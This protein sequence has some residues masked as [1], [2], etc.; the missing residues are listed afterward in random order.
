MLSAMRIAASGMQ[1]A[2]ARLDGAAKDILSMTTPAPANGT[3]NVTGAD[4][5]IDS[6]ADLTRKFTDLAAAHLS[7]VANA[8]VLQTASDMYEELLDATD[9]RRDRDSDHPHPSSC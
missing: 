5:Q 7:F 1:A 2:S 9:T 3:A 6:S 4:R 8:V